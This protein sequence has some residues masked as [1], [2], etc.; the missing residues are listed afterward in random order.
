MF[1]MLNNTIKLSIFVNM[2]EEHISFKLRNIDFQ[3]YVKVEFR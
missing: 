1:E 3:Y 2:Y